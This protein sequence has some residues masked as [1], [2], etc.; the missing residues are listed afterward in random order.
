MKTFAIIV[1]VLLAIIA[2]KVSEES[3]HRKAVEATAERLRDARREA[4]QKAQKEDDAMVEA[5]YRS[6]FGATPAA[7]KPQWDQYGRPINR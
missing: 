3:D 7:A 2:A 4:Q 1:I 5:A 6:S